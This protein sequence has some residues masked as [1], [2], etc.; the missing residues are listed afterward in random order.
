MDI[1]YTN[2]VHCETLQNYP[3]WDFG[4]ENMP[5]GNPDSEQR[6]LKRWKTRVFVR[7]RHNRSFCCCLLLVFD[8][9]SGMNFSTYNICDCV[10][11][12][13]RH[14]FFLHSPAR[15]FSKF[16]LK[17]TTPTPWRESISRPLSSNL[18]WLD[19]IQSYQIAIPSAVTSIGFC[20]Y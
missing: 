13:T 3:N 10:E 6:W 14:W 19:E 18:I 5:S 2:I 12:T 17:T 11:A 8:L 15:H 16:L 9:E 20:A 4:F 1:K 7:L